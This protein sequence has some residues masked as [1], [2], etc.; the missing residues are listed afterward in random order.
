MINGI[1]LLRKVLFKASE[2]QL[3]T[4][5]WLKLF[6]IIAR[7]MVYLLKTFFKSVRG[8]KTIVSEL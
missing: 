8:K 4:T 2:K 6:A 7:V 1:C 3:V 5:R